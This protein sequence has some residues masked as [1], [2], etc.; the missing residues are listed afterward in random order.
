[1]EPYVDRSHAGLA[2]SAGRALAAGL[3]VRE[4][5]A[6]AER[7]R[8][9]GHDDRGDAGVLGLEVLE[10]GDDALHRVGVQHVAPVGIVEGQHANA[11][12]DLDAYAHS[13]F[14]TTAGEWRKKFSTSRSY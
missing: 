5:G 14:L 12:G 3:Q 2:A 6:G 13:G 7:G 4:V 1:Q 8:R 9:A 10:G 11:V